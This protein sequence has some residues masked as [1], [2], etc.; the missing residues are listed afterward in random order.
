M[1]DVQ[2]NLNASVMVVLNCAGTTVNRCNHMLTQPRGL[3]LFE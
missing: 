3:N 1:D 2:E